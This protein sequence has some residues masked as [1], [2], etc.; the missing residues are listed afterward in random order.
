MRKLLS[1]NIKFACLVFGVALLCLPLMA[2]AAASFVYDTGTEF[3]TSGDF[4]G[5]GRQDVLVLDKS[6]G[7]SRIGYLNANSQLSWSAPLVSGVENATGVAVGRFLAGNRD[8]LA[9]TSPN[10]NWINLIDLSNS[11]SAPSPVVITPLGIGPHVLVTL[12]NPQAL[13]A[14]PPPTLLTASSANGV[15]PEEI[16]QLQI[17]L[18]TATPLGNFAETGPYDLGNALDL[19]DGIS[20]SF[21][22]G[23]V[24]AVGTDALDIL[25][26]TNGA[27]GILL[28]QTNLPPGSD[29]AMGFFNGETLPRFVCYQPGGSN[30]TCFPLAADGDGLVFGPTATLALTQAVRQIFYLPSSPSGAF[31]LQFENGVEVLKFFG[32]TPVTG[33][34]YGSGLASTNNVFTGIIPLAGGKFVLLDAAAGSLASSHAQVI[35]FDGTNFTQK[36]TSNL[37]ATSTR[38]T[39][40]NIW[41]FQA[42]PF[43]NSNPGFIASLSLPDWSDGILGLAGTISATGETDGGT[44]TGLTGTVTNNLGTPPSGANFALPNQYQAAISIF[45][46]APPR[47]PDPVAVTISPSPGV[48]SGSIQISFNTLSASDQVFYRAG[49][50][51]GWHMY[52]GAFALTNSSDIQFYGTSSAGA[53]S[54]LLTA[55]YSIASTVLAAPDY[56]VTNG[57]PGTNSGFGTPTN[58]LVLSSSGTI[59]YGRSNLTGGSLWSINLDGSGETYI[60]SGARP[61]VSHDGRYLAF[62]RGTN[63]FAPAGGDVW[64]RDLQTGAEWELYPNQTGIVGYDWDLA[65][66]PN[67]IL[68]SACNFWRVG[69]DGTA[70]VF[71]LPQDCNDV[72]PAVNPA[73]GRIAYFNASLSLGGIYTDVEGETP[74]QIFASIDGRWPSW[75]PDGSHLSFAYLNN[76]RY[77]L[78]LVADIYTISTNG[79]EVSPISAFSQLQDGFFHGTIWAPDGNALV[80]AGTIQGTN[81]LWVIPLTADSRQCDCPAILLPTSPGDPID[82]AGSVVVAPAPPVP[83]PG[84]FI[85]SDPAAAVVYWST[86]YQGY[87]LECSTNLAPASGWTAITGP[88]YL[89]GN[90]I[91]YHDSTNSLQ[92]AKFFRL[93]YP[94]IIV[95]T[96]SP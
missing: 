47:V 14:L 24:R 61:R 53:R 65:S 73:D 31:L 28:S 81:G 38:A 27:G 55:N 94:A 11:N 71:S 46:Y 60:T 50:A 56:N 67:L 45:S 72:A 83:M 40:A 54:Q 4:K 48:Y 64:V 16:E 41:L 30:V 82:F 29:Y 33:N 6:T 15:P 18:G 39:R 86:N 19:P 68:D 95:L 70:L 51:D 8:S 32:E 88:Y 66:P 34:F 35:S 85:R 12:V 20:P 10:L 9:V 52:A 49:T 77:T 75:S 43:V 69:L 58:V 26:F 37:P 78:G 59:F 80:G 13:G 3:L 57:L 17:N 89:N 1:I 25:Q 87:A 76:P 92:N 22:V 79:N 7:N 42:E 23:V 91:E 74:S 44:S 62:S 96:P 21:A 2:Q 63:V 90:N 5:D 93:R 36:S 84:L